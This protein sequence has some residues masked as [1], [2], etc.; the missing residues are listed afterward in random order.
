MGKVLAHDGWCRRGARRSSDLFLSESTDD[1][2]C[3]CRWVMSSLRTPM[4]GNGCNVGW[5]GTTFTTMVVVMLAVVAVPSTAGPVAAAPLGSV[6]AIG[7]VVN[8]PSGIG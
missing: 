2:R 5:F 6:S 4:V 8:Y 3:S 1:R 7:T